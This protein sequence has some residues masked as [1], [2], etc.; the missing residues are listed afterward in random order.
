M[1]SI[2]SVAVNSELNAKGDMRNNTINFF[3]NINIARIGFIAS[4]FLKKDH[5]FD[6]KCRKAIK[7]LY[8]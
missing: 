4:D 7:I 2:A 5:S 6:E 8:D 3:I 1:T